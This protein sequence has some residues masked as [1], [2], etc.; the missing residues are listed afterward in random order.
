MHTYVHT[1]QDDFFFVCLFVYHKCIDVTLVNGCVQRAIMGAAVFSL[2]VCLVVST[3]WSV[4]LVFT[5]YCNQYLLLL[6]FLADLSH[7][8]YSRS[9]GTPARKC[10][11]SDHQAHLCPPL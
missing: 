7:E 2:V 5:G 6:L 9:A 8:H 4:S 10:S 11:P 3:C 1:E